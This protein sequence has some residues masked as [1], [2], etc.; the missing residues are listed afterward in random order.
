[1]RKKDSSGRNGGR[2]R[3]RLTSGWVSTVVV[4]VAV[5]GGV[6][7]VVGQASAN[8]ANTAAVLPSPSASPATV[9]Q[10]PGQ[11]L[12]TSTIADGTRFGSYTLR[13][14]NGYAVSISDSS[15][16]QS[17]FISGNVGSGDLY[18]EPGFG[19]YVTVG[20]AKKLFALNGNATPTYAACKA[21]TLFVGRI[22]IVAGTT[23]CLA[24]NG[25]MVGG[26][27]LQAS[28]AE[29]GTNTVQFTVWQDTA[30]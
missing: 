2:G 28:S 19:T 13:V 15:A 12:P 3:R 16:S 20:A 30:S 6:G 8:I 9:D 7:F 10:S 29:F 22:P 14:N 24:E 17:P 27:I 1:M 4:L 25:R 21:T 18:A 23:F 11:V 5:A 26:T